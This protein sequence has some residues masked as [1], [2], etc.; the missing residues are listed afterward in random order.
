[1]PT[2]PDNRTVPVNVLELMIFTDPGCTEPALIIDVV[3]GDPLPGSQVTVRADGVI[4]LFTCAAPT[5]FTTYNGITQQLYP[6]IAAGAPL[7][8]TGSKSSGAAFTSL[9]AQLVAAGI[10]IVDATPA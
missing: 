1:M 2:F 7:T 9:V 5:V 8:V 3:S 6:N 10:P 4:P